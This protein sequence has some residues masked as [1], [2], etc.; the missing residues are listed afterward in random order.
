MPLL[1]S[2]KVLPLEKALPL[3]KKNV[4]TFPNPLTIL[5]HSNYEIGLK[6]V[7]ENV[8]RREFQESLES[9]FATFKRKVARIESHEDSK[10]KILGEFEVAKC[11]KEG[12]IFLNNA[13]NW[14]KILQLLTGNPKN[15]QAVNKEECGKC[16]KGL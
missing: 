2:C 3:A 8:P 4:N 5:V 13:L 12:E 10:I 7:K 16:K 9:F 14:I 1:T 15:T 6:Y 11:L